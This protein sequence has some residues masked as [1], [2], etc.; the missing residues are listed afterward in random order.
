MEMENDERSKLD[1][2][3]ACL[4]YDVQCLNYVVRKLM[5]NSADLPDVESCFLTGGQANV[6]KPPE[7]HGYLMEGDKGD[8]DKGYGLPGIEVGVTPLDDKWQEVN[9]KA[10]MKWMALLKTGKVAY[11]PPPERRN[12]A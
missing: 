6:F 9:D 1:G 10:K 7:G 2:Y 3:L 4:R 12:D 11:E 5:G 8:F